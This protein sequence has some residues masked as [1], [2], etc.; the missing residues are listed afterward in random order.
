MLLFVGDPLLCTFMVSV[1]S[2][3]QLAVGDSLLLS[4]VVLKF[5]FSSS[6]SLLSVSEIPGRESR[7]AQLG[8]G[9]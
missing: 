7:L 1:P 5:R 2:L 4:Y 3:F 9:V 8:S 6:E